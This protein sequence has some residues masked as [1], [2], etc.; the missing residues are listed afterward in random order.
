MPFLF[1]QNSAKNFKYALGAMLM[2][3]IKDQYL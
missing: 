2:P 3:G 1:K